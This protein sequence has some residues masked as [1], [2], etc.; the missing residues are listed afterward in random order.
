MPVLAANTS[1]PMR[2]KTLG[3]TILKDPLTRYGPSFPMVDRVV[4]MKLEC[5]GERALVR[6]EQSSSVDP[7]RFNRLGGHQVDTKHFRTRKPGF[8]RARNVFQS[9]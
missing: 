9:L 8:P 3:P 2:S 1:N 4:R 7:P 6:F 5:L